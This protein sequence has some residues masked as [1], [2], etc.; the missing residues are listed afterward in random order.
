[1]RA[2]AIVSESKI[3]LFLLL[4]SCFFL[5]GCGAASTTS[6]DSGSSLGSNSK[7]SSSCV[8]AS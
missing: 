8:L 4:C 6:S 1:M 2:I 5:N 3:G 7:S